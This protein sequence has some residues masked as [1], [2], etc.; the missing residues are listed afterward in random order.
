MSNSSKKKIEE[1]F[2]KLNKTG[3]I[4]NFSLGDAEIE[5]VSSRGIE[6]LR[7]HATDFIQKRIAPKEPKNDG[8]QTPAKGHPVFLAQHACGCNDR[9]SVEQFFGFKKG[10]LLKEKEVNLIVDVIVFS[11]SSVTSLSYVSSNFNNFFKTFQSSGLGIDPELL[12]FL[13]QWPAVWA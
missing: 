2:S 6:I 1:V 8:H 3:R 4:S 7:L 12:S 9:D 11:S 5:Y 10:S 13:N